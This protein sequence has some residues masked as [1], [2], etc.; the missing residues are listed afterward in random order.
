MSLNSKINTNEDIILIIEKN[1]SINKVLAELNNK[2]ILT[3]NV[4]YRYVIKIYVNIT[5]A[6]LYIGVHKFNNN[7]TNWELINQ[8]FSVNNLLTIKVTFPEG[9]TINRFASILQNRLD[10]DSISFINYCNDASILKQFGIEAS[11]LEGYLRPA[12]YT[13]NIGI[14]ISDILN[15]LI[16]EQIKELNKYTEAINNSKYNKYEILI[17]ASIIEAETP[18]ITER[19]IVSGVYH[20]RLDKKMLLQADPTLQYI[21]KERKKRILY[22]DLTI[23]NPYNTYKYAGLPPGPINNPS[24]SSIEAA[25]Y[26]ENHNYYY[27]VATGDGTNKH[28]FATSH[29]EHLK[30]KEIYKRN[31]SKK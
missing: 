14:G 21:F 18:V 24:A 20:N 26:P 5:D 15:L 27:F 3:P 17:L 7:L 22:S 9:I 31:I 23:D 11:N 2:N 10:I 8:L 30:Y 13:F 16:K 4:F 28:N 29:Q 1:M 19:K 12:T 25:I 6:K